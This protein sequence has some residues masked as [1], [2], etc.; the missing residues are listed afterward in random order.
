LYARP[1]S[2]VGSGGF[3]VGKQILLV[4]LEQ[5]AHNSVAATMKGAFL[6]GSMLIPMK[7]VINS[8]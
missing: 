4:F 5:F 1:W 3:Q 7:A 6:S 8:E 2:G